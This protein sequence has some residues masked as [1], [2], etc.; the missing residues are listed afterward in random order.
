LE[1]K[2]RTARKGQFSQERTRLTEQDF[3][4]GTS[5]K[6]SQDRKTR[7]GLPGQNCQDRTART[8]LPGK[9]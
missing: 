1:R 4:D 6:V 9:D 8:G 5:R 7:I 3:Q 2:D